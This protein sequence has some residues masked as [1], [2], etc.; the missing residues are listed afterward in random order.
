MRRAPH[1]AIFDRDR[2]ADHRHPAG[3]GAPF[4]NLP[5]AVLGAIVIA[6]VIGLMDV[7][8]LKRFYASIGS[9]SCWRWWRCSGF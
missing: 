4:Y 2:R 6:S 7:A 8:E 5:N 9:I 1:A 3:A